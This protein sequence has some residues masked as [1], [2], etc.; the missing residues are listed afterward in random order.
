MDHRAN[1]ND[2]MFCRCN[3]SSAI[4]LNT[5]VKLTKRKRKLLHSDVIRDDKN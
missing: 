5:A 1:G 3:L 2:E 4:K